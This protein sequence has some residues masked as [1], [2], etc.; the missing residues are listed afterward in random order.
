M[1]ADDLA[2]ITATDQPHYGEV[3]RIVEIFYGFITVQFGSDVMNFYVYFDDELDVLTVSPSTI[4]LVLTTCQ[5][6][7]GAGTLN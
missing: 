4:S 3:G 5:D 2:L 7:S 6:P 1:K